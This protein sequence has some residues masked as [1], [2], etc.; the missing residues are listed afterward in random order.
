MLFR[1]DLRKERPVIGAYMDRIKAELDPH[2]TEV[3]KRVYEIT[4]RFGGNVPGVF[5]PNKSK[6]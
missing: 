3:H 1:W 6:L 5:E 2:Y 4:E